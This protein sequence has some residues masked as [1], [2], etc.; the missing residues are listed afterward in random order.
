MSVVIWDSTGPPGKVPRGLWPPASPTN[1]NTG[2]RF[3]KDFTARGSGLSSATGRR[4]S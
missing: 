4:V 3:E 1:R 2:K